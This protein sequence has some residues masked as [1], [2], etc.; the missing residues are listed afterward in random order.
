ML[1][2][3]SSSR[4]QIR[5]SFGLI[6]VLAKR[7]FAGPSAGVFVMRGGVV[8]RP[9]E[10]VSWFDPATATNIAAKHGPN[11]SGP[12]EARAYPRCARIVSGD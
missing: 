5:S 11:P 12:L 3:F 8:F 9:R 1:V 10:S 6:A 7:F 2:F 4:C